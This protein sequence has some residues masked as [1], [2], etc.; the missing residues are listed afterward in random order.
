MNEK[1]LI[2]YAKTLLN[3]TL[4]FDE[5]AISVFVYEEIKSKK[6]ILE[7]VFLR[8]NNQDKKAFFL[9]AASGSGKTKFAAALKKFYRS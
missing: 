8:F 2:N 1:D 6:T 3:N 7:D 4:T 9:S 5:K